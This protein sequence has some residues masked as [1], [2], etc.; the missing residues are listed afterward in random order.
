MNT[1]IYSNESSCTNPPQDQEHSAVPAQQ[2][3]EEE[4]YTGDGRAENPTEKSGIIPYQD[5]RAVIID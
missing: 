2:E 5:Q 4:K 3:E 1:A